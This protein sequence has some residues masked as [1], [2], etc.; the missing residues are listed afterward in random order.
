MKTD[1]DNEMRTEYDFSGGV[2]GKHFR[3]LREG[4]TVTIYNEDGTKTIEKYESNEGVIVLDPDVR[5][6][7]PDSKT[8]NRTLR[9]LIA[10]IPQVD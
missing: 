2:R 1:N 7:F 5:E 3:K 10:L 8:V 4:Y 6:F 9:S